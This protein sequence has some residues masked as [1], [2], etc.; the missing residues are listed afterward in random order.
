MAEAI[1]SMTGPKLSERTAVLS[2][3]TLFN[4]LNL[5]EDKYTYIINLHKINDIKHI[6]DFIDAVNHKLDMNGY[7]FCCVETKDQR[8]KRILKKFPPVINYIFYFFDFII[9]RI[10][11]K[12]KL[13][14]PLYFSLTHGNNA[15]ISRAEALGRLCRGGFRIRQESFIGNHAVHRSK[16]DK[17]TS[18]EK[19][20]L[21]MVL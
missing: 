18:S 19:R 4:I 14:R 13:T 3:T 1:I 20:E 16:K 2:T 7:F 21:Y 17:R 8:K 12:L 6:D 9:K 10:L 11:P 5:P 15:V